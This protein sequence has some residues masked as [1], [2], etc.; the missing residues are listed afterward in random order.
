MEEVQGSS[1][2]SSTI[3]ILSIRM[4]PLWKHFLIGCF[5][6]MNSC[7][8]DRSDW[9]YVEDTNHGDYRIMASQHNLSGLWISTHWYP[10][11]TDDAGK[12]CTHQMQAHQRGDKLVLESVAEPDKS[13]M[14]INLVIDRNLATGSWNETS[15]PGGEYE[16]ITYSGAM[17]LI[18][19]EDGRQMGGQWV[20]IGRE[21]L[22]DGTYEPH[23][24]NGRWRIVR[25]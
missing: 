11:A 25:G 6:Y 22:D 21:K 16:G 7:L 12:A 4:L 13:H 18:I 2:C 24:Y 23:I 8:D 5:D 15:L 20:G 1:P 9:P 19:S 17:Q 3:L 10:N 14:T